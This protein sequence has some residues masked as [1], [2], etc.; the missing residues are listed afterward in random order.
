MIG[1]MLVKDP[2]KRCALK[3]L[4]E[5]LEKCSGGAEPSEINNLNAKDR[6]MSSKNL[7]KAELEKA[8]LDYH[9][10]PAPGKI[11]VISSKACET[12]YALSLAY[13]PGVALP[14]MEIK[15]NPT[16][17]WQ[18]TSKPNMVG[19]VS[20]GTAVL[21]LGNIGPEAGI[22][23]MEG[24]AVLFKR[25]ADIDA[26]PICVRNVFT[27][28]GKTDAKKLI[29]TVERLEPCFGGINLEDIA[30]PACFEVEQTLKKTMGIPVFHDDQHGTAIISLAG[31]VNALKLAGKKIE[32]CRFVING[33]GAAGIACSEFYI[34]AGANRKNFLMCDSKGV[35]Y[36]GRE[37]LNA[38]KLAFANETSARTLEEALVGADIF[39][40]VSKG[41][42]LTSE[43]VSKMASGAVVFAMANP[44]PEIFPDQALAGGAFV[45][46]TGRTDFPNQVNNVLGFPGIFRGALDV[47][48][49][50]I[51][52][53]MKLAA[54]YAI[55]SIV[56]EKVTDE[57]YG[58]LS[59]AY[60]E[61]AK[62][63]V[64][65]GSCPLKTTLVIPKPFD[66]RVVPRVARKVAE[67]A[68]KSGVATVMIENL[69]EY[70]ASVAERIKRSVS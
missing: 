70:E 17:V 41:N 45:V 48:A 10:S 29:E 38:E 12:Q 47:R 49:T 56:H 57:I 19:V 64:F 35:I 44:V 50:D 16:A 3:E 40:G 36:K 66:P 32:N 68:M 18:Y 20:D 58:I 54:S 24:K 13:T 23:V 46:G 67:A 65:D 6:I 21:G 43:M 30:A 7:S 1:R 42:V 52:Q 11:S 51:N 5:L 9:R 59:S 34:A 15:A 8:S 2:R 31:I 26:F 37:D 28:D 39:I 69:D 55:A 63:G 14:C 60:P 62:A 53:E 33:A 4:M 22:P 25:F 61:D 27:A